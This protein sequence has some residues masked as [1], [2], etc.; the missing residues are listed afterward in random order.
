M[1]SDL[2]IGWLDVAKGIGII[3]VIAGHTFCMDWC[4]PIY[5]FHLPLFFV[6]SGMLIKES[7][8]SNFRE[9][10]FHQTRSILFPFGFMLLI[11]IAIVC[12]IP[13][14][15]GCLSIKK[16]VVDV[17]L[18]SPNFAQN[19]SLWYL[20]C[21][22]F[23]SLYF[24]LIYRYSTGRTKLRIG[25]ILLSCLVSLLAPYLMRKIQLPAYRLPFKMDS[26]LVA[27]VFIMLGCWFKKDLIKIVSLCANLRFVVCMVL[28]TA[29]ASIFNGKTNVS[30]LFFGRIGWVYYPVAIIGVLSVLS[31]SRLLENVP[32]V[33][34]ILK[35]YGQHSLI[36]FAFQ[37]MMI[38]TY[39]LV[40]FKLSGQELILYGQN[41]L[42]HQ[43]LSFVLVSFVGAPMLVLCCR[44]FNRVKT[45]E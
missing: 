23:A 35:L 34:S 19:S 14:W 33:S 22:W 44:G 8:M 3:L 25:I 37:S 9:Y 21:F 4:Y 42:V 30:S 26:A 41:P 1:A 16:I 36:I 45:H 17:Y 38:R 32:Y 11:S 15:R 10:F 12:A 20:I 2:R 40:V 27:V 5:A 13:E 29:V 6:I 43:L 18:G 39:N 31:L 28:V 24:G 7:R